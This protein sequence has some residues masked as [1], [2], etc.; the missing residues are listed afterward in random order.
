M[1]NNQINLFNFLGVQYSE[2][3]IS[4][5]IVSI[6]K[7]DKE[8]LKMFLEQLEIY[9]KV[10]YNK[11]KVRTEHNLSSRDGNRKYG[12][13]DIWIGYED[14]TN[15]KR[16]IIENK[17]FAA[18]QYRQINRYRQYLDEE[19]AKREGYL[20]Y[21]TILK[22]CPDA[23]SLKHRS[24]NVLLEGDSHKSF[25]AISYYN[26]VLPWLDKVDKMTKNIKLKFLIKD[27][28]ETFDELSKP[29]EFFLNDKSAKEVPSK[30]RIDFYSLCEYEFWSELERQVLIK[31]PNTQISSRRKYSFNKIQKN[32]SGKDFGRSYG[33]IFNDRRVQIQR[34]KDLHQLKFSKGHFSETDDKWIA[35]E[36]ESFNTFYIKSID[37][38]KVAIIMAQQMLTKFDNNYVI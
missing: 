28:V 4:K 19:G 23:S 29:L 26:D 18:D 11:C 12:R 37:S 25:K 6:M 13:A 31:Y 16:I 34:K 20:F 17:I 35:I 22:Y 1:N 2:T 3:A 27:F 7:Q 32:Q 5:F 38:K 21:L 14:E 24:G 36:S 30:Y 10:D 33:F 9:D 8:Y 15:S